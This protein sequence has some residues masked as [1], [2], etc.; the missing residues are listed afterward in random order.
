[1]RFLRA[2]VA[3]GEVLDPVASG[4]LDADH[5]RR[6]AV[7]R[8]AVDVGSLGGTRRFMSGEASARSRPEAVMPK[9]AVSPAR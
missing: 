8:I 7:V 6:G 5:P 1:M 9:R 2:V 3:V 4:S